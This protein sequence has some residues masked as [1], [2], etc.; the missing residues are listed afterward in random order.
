MLPLP[1]DADNPIAVLLLVQSYTVPATKEPLKTTGA[2]EDPL[3]RTWSLV[4]LTDGVGL[5]AIVATDD[6]P[7]QTPFEGVTVIVAFAVTEDVFVAVNE[8]VP[9]P[10]PDAARPMLVLLLV[11]V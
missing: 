1:D 11:Q 3:H 4:G 6:E 9:V 10:V 2:V 7:A 8:G 5:T